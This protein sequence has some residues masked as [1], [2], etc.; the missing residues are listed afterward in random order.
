M[1]LFLFRVTIII[2]N[3]VIIQLLGSTGVGTG[4]DWE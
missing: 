1:G 4:A 3:K 2:I